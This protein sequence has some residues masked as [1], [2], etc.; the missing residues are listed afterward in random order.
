M[1]EKFFG[2]PVIRKE[3]REKVTG[4]ARYVDDLAFPEM[5]H[6]V[7][8]R[9]SIARG[10]IRGIRFGGGFPWDEFT[11]VT[12]ADIPGK[13]EIALIEHD[14]PCLAAELINH[15]EEAIVLLAH[16]DRYLLEEARRA[17]QID[18][19]PLP[20]IF[21]IED[22]LTKRAVIFGE[23][24]VFK[25][26]HMDKGDVDAAWA[27]AD[28]IVEGEY[29]TGAQE[30]LYIENQGMVAVANPTDGVTIWGSLQCP[31]YVHKAL[32]TLFGQYTHSNYDVAFD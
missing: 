20:A 9:S 4:R 5:L 2:H 10:R 29:R 13:N 21:S 8:V 19:E 31:F 26:Y 7:T 32:V 11:I 30:Q 23:D 17:V 6:G 22:S 15:P 16:P 27:R 14:Q 3:G 1:E 28:V 18:V 12:A 25:T 24:N